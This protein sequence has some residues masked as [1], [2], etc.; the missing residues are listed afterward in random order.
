MTQDAK[1][2]F[3]LGRQLRTCAILSAIAIAIIALLHDKP[4]MPKLLAG[5]PLPQQAGV[6]LAVGMLYWIFGVIGFKYAAARKTNEAT[7]ESYS[8]LDLR[9]WNPVWIALAAGFGEEL[10][11]R[12]ALQPM[13]G[14]WLT[15][16]LFVLA[17]IKAYNFNQL[18]GR[19]LIQ[20]G[21][22]FVVSVFFGFVAQY[23]GLVAAMIIH[24][25]ID[26]AGLLAIRRMSMQG[27]AAPQATA[28]AAGRLP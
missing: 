24:A 26:I 4:N 19:V 16:A 10:L 25:A 12:G 2:R 5:L 11:F 22:V 9:G 23:V 8:R 18:N 27:T 6:G 14:I 21:G 17:H 1:I 15:S 3:T 28:R 13:L 20:A 7:V